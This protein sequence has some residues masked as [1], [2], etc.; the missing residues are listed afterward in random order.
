MDE[1]KLGAAI[2]GA[3]WGIAIFCAIVWGVDL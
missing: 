3:L 2:L 1:E